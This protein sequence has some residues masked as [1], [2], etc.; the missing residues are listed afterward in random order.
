MLFSLL[1]LPV[2]WL[3]WGEM[4]PRARLKVATT[5]FPLYDLAR[6]VAG[7]DVE[8]VLLV[9]PGA[10]PHTF[11]AKPGTIRA[12]TGSA[13]LFA[14][15]HGFDD[16]AVRLAQGAGVGRVQVVDEHIPLRA[17][18]HAGHSHTTSRAAQKAHTP[19]DPHYWLSIPNAIHMVHTMTK[20]LGNLD[21]PA[22]SGYE[23]RARAYEEQLR[24][25]DADLHALLGALPRRSIATF[26]DAFDYFAVTYHLQ[27]VATFETSP[28]Q[29]P[30]PRQVEAFQRQVRA[31][32]LRVLFIEPQLPPGAL[33]SLV[34]DLR[35]TLQELD[36]VGGMPGRE[37]YL[38]MMRFN[39][40]Q[41]AASL[42]E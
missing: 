28:G 16:W 40:S 25:V 37:S 12:V 31:H 30:P 24:A 7:A 9:P 39:A 4:A 1:C 33:A 14:I 38:A 34:Q 26:H 3:A 8:V 10:S 36:P 27:V 11:E 5:I 22:R 23:Q 20:T 6:N 17:M 42:R 21:P 15:G 2:P 29:T 19:I 13:V 32:K 18:T 35:I 41:I